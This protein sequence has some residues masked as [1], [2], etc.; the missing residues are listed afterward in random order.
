[1]GA[2]K[3][4]LVAVTTSAGRRRVSAGP[5]AEAFVNHRLLSSTPLRVKP[6]LGCR[7]LCSSTTPAASIRRSLTAV[8]ATAG[9][10]ESWCGHE[11]LNTV[12]TAWVEDH[13]GDPE[14]VAL[15]DIRGQVVKHRDEGS[16]FFSTRY[17]GMEADYLDA[18]IPGAV[19]V[20]WTK[21][22]AHTDENG[23]PAQLTDR[24]SFVIAMQERGVG[25]DKRVVV[26]DNG[27]MLFA[28]RFWWA[29][30]R[31]GHDRVAVMDGGWA[32][33]QA[34][35]RD[36]TPD[37]PCPLK[38][39]T[40]WGIP[41]ER[42]RPGLI[43]TSADIR[44]ALARREK[45]GGGSD[46][47]ADAAVQLLDARAAAQ[48]TGEVRRARLGGHIP[49]AVNT[50][51]RSFLAEGTGPDGSFRVFKDLEGITEV[52][53]SAAVD[54]SPSAAPIIAYCNGG[55]ASTVVLFLLFQLRELR[56]DGAA[57]ASSGSDSD[58]FGR[59]WWSNYDGSWNEWGNDELAPVER[60]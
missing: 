52:F 54:T 5:P 28:T 17:E 50:P 7:L 45:A 13:L 48:Y 18:H 57:T 29:M 31:F 34:E 36:I 23:V 19:F 26:Y 6:R 15:V 42:E 58:G 12:T 24:E 59:G 41:P 11:L 37:C 38:V 22:I 10:G 43:T 49:G 33:W 44:A 8:M 25:A 2:V 51:Y 21:D 16:D 32:K 40:E 3:W 4:L 27:D 35:E 1:M 30:R 39:Y 14:P 55:V 9:A 60:P 47:Q 20:D 53:E 46:H 56:G